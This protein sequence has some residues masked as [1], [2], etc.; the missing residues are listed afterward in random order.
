LLQRARSGRLK[1]L[2]D[3]RNQVDLTHI[4]NAVQAHLCAL[5]ALQAGRAGGQ[6]YF[7]TDGAPVV[8]W[9]WVNQ[10]LE[11]LSIPPLKRRV[12]AGVA[13]A[14]GGAFE[15]VYNRAGI[16]AEPPLTRFAACE[17]SRSHWFS[18]ERARAEIGYVPMS[19]TDRAFSAMIDAFKNSGLGTPC[20]AASTGK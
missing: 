11:A 2:G 19:D 20:P 1:I 8:L 15:A 5:E 7:I 10:V 6:A 13:K 3:G 17:L 9:A 14:V 12:S 18:I 4:D 16:T